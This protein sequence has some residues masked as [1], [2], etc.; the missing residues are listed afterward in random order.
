MSRGVGHCYV[1]CAF[2]TY[3]QGELALTET[4]GTDRNCVQENACHFTQVAIQ[5]YLF[6]KVIARLVALV[7][8]L[9]PF[10][11]AFFAAFPILSFLLILCNYLLHT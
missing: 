11:F 3:C 1:P 10:S 6:L 7:L 2:R 4:V 9:H 5:F 8:L